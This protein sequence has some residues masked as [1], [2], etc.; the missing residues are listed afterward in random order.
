MNLARPWVLVLGLGAVAGVALAG[1]LWGQRS[2]RATVAVAHPE[3]L[4][5]LPRYRRL[6]TRLRRRVALFAA[7]VGLLAL[8][9]TMLVARPQRSAASAP[10]RTTRDI[11]LC[12]D[13]SGSMVEYNRAA[14]ARVDD[15]LE[16]FDG[17]R[18]GL[19]IFN[20][21]AVVVFPLTTDYRFARETFDRFR[22]NFEERG[23]TELAGSLEG[24]GSSLVPDGIASCALSFPSRDDDRSR[25]II[26]ATDNQVEGSALTSM[27]AVSQLAIDRHIRIHVLYPLYGY[28]S[29]ERPEIAEMRS[30]AAASGGSFSGLDR[31]QATGMIVER[32]EQTEAR[33]LDDRDR[34]TN[35]SEPRWWLLVAA[36]AAVV[37]VALGARSRL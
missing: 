10:G 12:L 11:M 23:I 22:T 18:V 24:D 33:R 14:L 8:A 36:G 1:W 20:S 25:S 2:S 19:T 15:L 6:R 21:S 9:L 16:A 7:I 3:R 32:I 34:L 35:V 5:D 26:V 28:E 13:V 4:S 27:A 29:V 37:L 30:L 31:A 17:E